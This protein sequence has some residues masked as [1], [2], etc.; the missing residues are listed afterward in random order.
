MTE[1]PTMDDDPTPTPT[2]TPTPKIILTK[3]PNELSN[4]HEPLVF[5]SLDA[6]MLQY[7]LRQLPTFVH[8]L[9]KYFEASLS[10]SSSSQDVA[11]EISQKAMRVLERVFVNARVPASGAAL[12]PVPEEASTSERVY[13]D[14][15]R[16]MRFLM[17]SDAT[18]FLL[19]IVLMTDLWTAALAAVTYHVATH[20]LAFSYGLVFLLNAVNFT[21]FPLLLVDLLLGVRAIGVFEIA[22]PARIAWTIGVCVRLCIFE[23]N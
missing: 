14:V 20:D 1:N 3:T 10:P 5:E 15:L 21:S 8:A 23:E 18:W 2:P 19:G 22:F 7:D 9:M 16:P 17:S 12:P 4:T 13:D 11:T 6:V